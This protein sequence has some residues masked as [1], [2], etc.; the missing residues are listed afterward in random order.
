M[1]WGVLVVAPLTKPCAAVEGKEPFLKSETAGIFQIST[2]SSGF[3][4]MNNSDASSSSFGVDFPSM[5]E[6]GHY[7]INPCG[8]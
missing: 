2:S 6:L 7:V 3:I 4:M 8:G 5:R 1:K